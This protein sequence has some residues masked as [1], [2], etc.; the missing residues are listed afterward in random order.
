[1]E[2]QGLEGLFI[3]RNGSNLF[4]EQIQSS[5]DICAIVSF[6]EEFC[7]FLSEEE[8]NF[9][10][11]DIL[12][13]SA[14]PGAF[15]QGFWEAILRNG[16]VACRID[17]RAALV[18]ELNLVIETARTIQTMGTKIL[19]GIR[20]VSGGIIGKKGSI[21]VDSVDNPA[22]VIGVCDGRGGLLSPKDEG[23][24]MK[25]IERIREEIIKKLYS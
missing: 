12:I 11:E 18:S 22:R 24:Y 20:V 13:C 7:P 8:A 5:S 23:P 21:V 19:D 6:G 1:L 2:Q 3:S 17:S 15:P 16:I 25:D 10:R 4:R 9:M 14:F